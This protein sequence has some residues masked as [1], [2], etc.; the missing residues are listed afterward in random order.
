MRQ[1][2]SRRHVLALG[3]AAASV[4]P[5]RAAPSQNPDVVIVGA[6]IAGLA[7]ARVL[8]A[9]GRSVTVL[10]ASPRIGGRVFT[11]IATFGVPFERGA[12]WIHGADENVM[13]GLARYYGFDTMDDEPQEILYV[14]SKRATPVDQANYGRAYQALGEGIGATAHEGE[15]MAAS[16]AMPATLPA[17][18]AAWLPTAAAAIGPLEA[19]VDLEAMSVQD[20]HDREDKEPKAGVRQGYGMLAGRMADG[21]PVAANTR[22]DRIKVAA[23]M[24]EV[25]TDRGSLRARAALV[26]VSTGVLAS[27]RIT[28]DPVFDGELQKALTGLPMGLI[29]KMALHFEQKS[30][31]VEFPW[32]A[33]VVP[34]VKGER[35]HSFLMRPMGLPMAICLVGGSLAWDMATQPAAVG[36]DFAR[37]RLRVVLGSN[38]DKGFRRAAITDWATN[39]HTLGAFTAPL[40]GA[41]G[42]RAKLDEPIA[43]RVFLAGEAQGGA[44]CQS[45]EGAYES[46][47]KVAA[48]MLKFLKR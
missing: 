34:Q 39:P 47:G 29:T 11:D 10:E 22:V 27:G 31:A 8:I 43:E 35:G 19:G 4:R 17:E 14:G 21:L 16:A 41:A 1:H 5:V 32:N 24:V 28:F 7:A 13:T 36:I 23:D 46:G 2:L 37:D 18:Q 40:P 25:T 26:T 33:T 15:D 48:K 30:P 3:A 42:G 20:W 9:G 38:A 12:A 44:R 45:V 6:G